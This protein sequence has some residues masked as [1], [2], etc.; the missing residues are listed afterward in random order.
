[1]T[2]RDPKNIML[3]GKYKK[4]NWSIAQLKRY[5][6]YLLYQFRK[7]SYARQHCLVCA[8]L[9][10]PKDVWM[11]NVLGLPMGCWAG[12]GWA[13]E[14][15]G[16]KK[17]RKQNRVWT[18]DRE[19]RTETMMWLYAPN[20]TPSQRIHLRGLSLL[21]GLPPPFT[22][23]PARFC[24]AL[25]S[26]PTMPSANT[27]KAQVHWTETVS[28]MVSPTRSGAFWGWGTESV[29]QFSNLWKGV[30]IKVPY[31]VIWGLT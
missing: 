29:P 24:H 4:Q 5:D 11:L 15:K 1:M 22:P 20:S 10:L 28:V 19:I 26:V 27:V 30:M 12:N 25:H 9:Q 31:R 17:K 3:S 21:G 18:N 14:L 16:K 23:S 13:R 6:L 2:W 7:W 8:C